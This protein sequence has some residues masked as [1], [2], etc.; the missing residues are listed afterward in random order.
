MAKKNKTFKPTILSWLIEDDEAMT[1]I[2]ED[3]DKKYTRYVTEREEEDAKVK[4]A[5]GMRRCFMNKALGDIE[6]EAAGTDGEKDATEREDGGDDMDVSLTV[7]NSASTRFARAVAQN[8][9]VF[10]AVTSAQDRQWEYTPVKNDLIWADSIEDQAQAEVRNLLADESLRVSEWGYKKQD[11]F[12]DLITY[13][14]L[15]FNIRM[16]TKYKEVR[17]LAENGKS[18]ISKKMKVMNHP[19]VAPLPWESLFVDK[20]ISNI[21]DQNCI[22]ITSSQGVHEIEEDNKAF[23]SEDQIEKVMKEWKNLLH[24]VADN[25]L[26]EDLRANDNDDDNDV[27]ETNLRRWDVYYRVK[28]DKKGKKVVEVDD[29][30][31]QWTLIWLVGYGADPKS[32]I[33]VKCLSKFDPDDEIPIKH[34]NVLPG[35][36]SQFY[37]PRMSEAARPLYAQE[38]TFLNLA[39]DAAA[40]QNLPPVLWNASRFSKAPKTLRLVAGSNHEVDNI[41]GAILELS[42]SEKA[43]IAVELIKVLQGQQDDAYTLNPNSMGE[44]FGNISATENMAANGA[45]RQPQLASVSYVLLQLYPWM[46]EKISRYWEAYGDYDMIMQICK[47]PLGGAGT[48]EDI[49]GDFNIN[50]NIVSTYEDRITQS[51]MLTGLIQMIASNEKLLE[52]PEHKVEIYEFL[53]EI[54]TRGGIKN[55]SRLV[56]V[57]SG[58]AS[59]VQTMENDMIWENIVEGE[60]ADPTPEENQDHLVHIS[61]IDGKLLNI[62]PIVQKAMRDESP[63]EKQQQYIA[64]DERLRKH[65]ES[66]ESMKGR[67][68]PNAPSAPTQLT[69]GQESGL[70]QSAQMGAQ[71]GGN[72]NAVKTRG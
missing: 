9:A 56:T 65:K 19:I 51:S 57:K 30:K 64:Y 38:C 50:I 60:N 52:S 15:A 27:S 41:N 2:G 68:G 26:E 59:Y 33:W 5:S 36:G 1:T 61:V 22:F 32:A 58:D 43:G 53:K 63:D 25:E 14:D 23:G 11:S 37:H 20:H 17:M 45:T 31:G 34:V 49:Y 4:V 8:A 46:G 21:Q 71:L 39:I 66:H 18:V 70:E 54:M 48:I 3:L 55:A 6:R 28:L 10:N 40:K 7:A 67:S 72:N 16:K 12:T 29:M 13:S 35:G 42:S 24:N 62:F 69:P 44:K 47:M